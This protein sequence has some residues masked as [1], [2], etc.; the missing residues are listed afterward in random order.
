M[1]DK[2]SYEAIDQYK[3]KPN[4]TNDLN[5][6]DFRISSVIGVGLAHIKNWNPNYQY[7]WGEQQ[8]VRGDGTNE[9]HVKWGDGA[10]ALSM[11]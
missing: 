5:F 2:F 7:Q 6:F 3:V 4:P 1:G 9:L 8:G 10:N 11:G